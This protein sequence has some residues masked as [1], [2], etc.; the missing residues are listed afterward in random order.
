MRQKVHYS[1]GATPWNTR[2]RFRCIH[3]SAHV[4][5]TDAYCYGCGDFIDNHERQLMRLNM[6]ELAKKNIPSLIGLGCFVLLV[7]YMCTL[8]VKSG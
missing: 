6:Q 4:A 3:C 2:D 8:A 7:I 5:I 1:I